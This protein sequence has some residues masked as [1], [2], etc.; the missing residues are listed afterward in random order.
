MS[1]NR[2]EIKTLA[3]MRYQRQAA[4]I[5][6]EIHEALYAAAEPGV[7]PAELNQLSAKVIASHGAKSNFLGYYGYPATVCISVN[8]TVVH[9]IPN[10]KPLQKGDLVSFDC[11]CYIEAEGKSWHADSC[12]S[13]V[14][15]QRP[16]RKDPSNLPS[17]AATSYLDEENKTSRTAQLNE[18]TR[19]AMWAGVAA[20]AKSRSVAGVGEAVENTIEQQ[21]KLYGWQAD[22]VEEFIGHGIGTAMHQPPDVLNYRAR[23]R[24]EKLRPGMVLCVEPILVAG[25]NKVETLGDNWTVKTIDRKLACHW[26]SQVAILDSGIAVLNQPDWGKAGLADFGVVPVE[27]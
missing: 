14:V 11:G 15:G 8:E 10:D 24:Q 17:I 16:L 21:A 5:V 3:Q 7:T 23:G 22:I 1:R 19:L 4:L 6:N 26:E 25:S 18:I 9:G 13:I 12:F 27:L 2:V 20:L